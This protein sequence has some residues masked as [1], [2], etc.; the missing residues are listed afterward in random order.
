MGA[1]AR[2][3][4]WV[5][6]LLA[7][8]VMVVEGYDLV[9]YGNTL[10]IMLK[11]SDMGL[12]VSAAGVIGS[13][14][15]V[16]MLLGGL[17]VGPL[18][19]RLGVKGMLA[20]GIGCFS[21]V[22]AGAALA[23]HPWMLGFLRLVAGWGLGAVMP[24]CMAMTRQSTTSRSGPL[25]ISAVMAGIP[26][27]GIAAS[28]FTYLGVGALGWRGLF[29]VGALLSVLLLPFVPLFAKRVAVHGDEAPVPRQGQLVPRPFRFVVAIGCLATF[30]FLLTFYGLVTWL[31]KLMTELRV[32]FEDALQLTL[33]LN[34]GGVIGSVA[35]GFVATR[36]GSLKTLG[37][38]GI[39]C[40]VM[41]LAIPSGLVSGVG[42][43]VVVTILGV[44][45]PTT[46]N[47]VNAIVAEVVPMQSRAASLGRT[48][49]VGR[50][51]AITAPLVGSWLLVQIPQGM[52]FRSGAGAVFIAFAGV[53]VLGVAVSLAFPRVARHT[54]AKE[55]VN[56]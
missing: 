14:V 20:V 52:G 55:P 25:A 56:D 12:T 24:A 22:M 50:L 21:V 3:V 1:R 33:V 39:V 46:Q 42:L 7:A 53:C 28:I 44:V 11:D 51:G 32:P 8:T 37:C 36:L 45:A 38:A 49:G 54:L 29:G 40:A 5:A 43:M 26:L 16:G 34:A 19:R 10:P 9:I 18:V 6:V 47:L 2:E 35:T 4:D 30:C 48:L 13:A 23:H 41:L 31:P 15:F 27:G 17:S